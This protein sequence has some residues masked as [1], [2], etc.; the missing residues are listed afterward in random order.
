M[1]CE[2][3]EILFEISGRNNIHLDMMMFGTKCNT[4]K[5]DTF[6]PYFFQDKNIHTY[7]NGK[8]TFFESICNVLLTTFEE[9]K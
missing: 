2:I 5:L 9:L 6:N 3:L 1:L 8:G 4:I 7:F